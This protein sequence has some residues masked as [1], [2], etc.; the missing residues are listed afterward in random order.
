[1]TPTTGHRTDIT[2]HRFLVR[3]FTPK[4]LS[5]RPAIVVVFMMVIATYWTASINT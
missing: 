5:V 1:M 2:G 4:W 3:T